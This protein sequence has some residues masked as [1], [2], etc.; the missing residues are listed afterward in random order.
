M[1]T[2]LAATVSEGSMGSST[3]QRTESDVVDGET[4]HCCLVWFPFWVLV[5]LGTVGEIIGGLIFT[6]IA[7][8]YFNGGHDPCT[9]GGSG[10]PACTATMQKMTKIAAGF[11]LL[12]SCATF[13]VSPLVGA[14]ADACGRKPMIFIA[15]A[16]S[17]LNCALLLAVPLYNVSIYFVFAAGEL[18]ALFPSTV[19][20]QLWITDHTSPHD[21]ARFFARLGAAT[22]LDGLV[23]PIALLL[24]TLKTKLI[25]IAALSL[26]ALLIAAFCLRESRAHISNTIHDSSHTCPEHFRGFLMLFR[27]PA[28]RRIVF[29]ALAGSCNSDGCSAIFVVFMKGRFGYDSTTLAPI[30]FFST[31]SNLITQLFLI[32]PMEHHCGLKWVITS[33]FACGTVTCIG[34]LM[35][36]SRSWTYAVAA[37]SGLGNLAGPSL[38]A[39][40]TNVALAHGGEAGMSLGA[41]QSVFMIAKIVGPLAFR[42][43][44]TFCLPFAGAPWVLAIAVNAV[45]MV[46]LLCSPR[47]AFPEAPQAESRG[48]QV[49]AQ[50]GSENNLV[51]LA[52]CQNKSDH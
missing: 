25:L 10:S 52:A 35:A 43:T 5:L 39:L 15:Q 51:A 28:Y 22:S 37:W 26:A 48:W 49:S 50:E 44:Y 4:L 31:L 6:D 45:C 40:F 14:A 32:K 30:L 12:S 29:L 27:N 3:A 7:S 42:A 9:H 13:F 16:L 41:Y 2:P 47:S 8:A 33:S 18:A 38:T 11:G 20:F 36:P 23:V 46:I 24:L 21:R 1:S 17:T 34:Y 19:P